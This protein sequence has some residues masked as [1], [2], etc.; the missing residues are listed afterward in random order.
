MKKLDIS[1]IAIAMGLAF[2]AGAMAQGMSKEPYPSEKGSMAVGTSTS[3]KGNENAKEM[4]ADSR[5]DVQSDQGDAD[6]IAAKEKC[7]TLAGD[8]KGTC[9]SDAK[10]R[11]GKQ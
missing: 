5:K 1:A 11:F 8:A 10:A 7:E 4:G 9:M 2:S 6:Y 3:T